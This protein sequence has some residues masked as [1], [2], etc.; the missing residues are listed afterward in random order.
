MVHF[1]LR[2]RLRVASNL[3]EYATNNC[4]ICYLAVAS[5]LRANQPEFKDRRARLN[6]SH[7]PRRQFSARQ[8]L[9]GAGGCQRLMGAKFYLRSTDGQ[10]RSNVQY[11]GVW[12]KIG[13][14]LGFI[15]L[16]YRTLR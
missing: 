9:G 7:I 16:L 5:T 4:N 13:F 11:T 14:Y 8:K 2:A 3:Y 10:L 6:R 15:Y 12:P 1:F